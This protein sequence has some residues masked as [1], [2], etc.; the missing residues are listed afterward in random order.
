MG[1]ITG[2]DTHRPAITI[3][4]V[5]AGI[6]LVA[7]LLAA[8]GVFTPTAAQQSTLSDLLT[9]AFVL[10]GGDALIRVGRNIGDGLKHRNTIQ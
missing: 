10:I 3:P 6:P 9:W 7:N 5:I 4:Q 1:L 2:S 8:W